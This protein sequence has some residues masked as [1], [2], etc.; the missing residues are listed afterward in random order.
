[1]SSSDAAAL[2]REINLADRPHRK[3]W[4][5]SD[6]VTPEMIVPHLESEVAELRDAIFSLSGDPIEEIADVFA[7]LLNLAY[8]LKLSFADLDAEAV[9]KLRLRFPVE[10]K[11]AVPGPVRRTRSYADG[12]SEVIDG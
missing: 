2:V 5:P 3:G 12:T 4:K 7:V 6:L 11:P 9:R 1:M 10:P 8:R